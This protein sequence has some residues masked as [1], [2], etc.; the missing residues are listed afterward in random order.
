MAAAVISAPSAVAD[1][2]LDP[3]ARI[4]IAQSATSRRAAAG[5]EPGYVSMIIELTDGSD[6]DR[7]TAEG[8]V[9]WGQRENLVL[10]CVPADKVDEISR[11]NYVARMTLSRRLN[12]SLDLACAA[13]GVN[14]LHSGADGLAGLTGRGITVGFADSGFDPS[15]EVFDGRIVS[16]THFA[17]NEAKILRAETPAEIA[18]WSTD[19]ADMYHATHVGGILCGAGP[20][21]YQGVAAGASLVAATSQLY[22]AG[23]LACVE[24]VIARGRRAGQPVVVNMSLGSTIGPHDGT[25]PFC[26]YLDM[27]ADEAVIVLS[28][29]NDGNKEMSLSHTFTDNDPGLASLVTQR[30]YGDFYHLDSFYDCWSRDSRPVSIRIRAFDSTN[31]KYVWTSEWITAGDE[32]TTI[33]S[34]DRPD[35]ARYFKGTIMLAG[36][37]NPYNG[38][39]NA[40]IS[41]NTD[42]LQT[43]PNG[44]WAL[45]NLEIDFTGAP[46]VTADIY[47][48]TS[49][50][51]LGSYNL[52][53]QTKGNSDGSI[54]NLACGH[55][56]IS[57][58]SVNT[59]HEVKYPDGH[60]TVWSYIGDGPMSLTSSYGTLIDG[61]SLPHICA[62]GAV[63]ISAASRLYYDAHPDEASDIVYRTPGGDAYIPLSGTSMAA[64]HAA[65]IFALWLEAD[66]TLT[67]AEIRDI[68]VT[69]ASPIADGAVREG[70]GCI[71]ALAGLRYIIKHSGVTSP[72]LCPVV[73]RREGSRLVVESLD[74]SD[75]SAAVYDLT[76]RQIA[77]DALPASPVIVR[78][79]TASGVIVRK[80]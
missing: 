26:R 66:P 80:I 61:R 12:A 42:A 15:H 13:T 72:D 10:A 54:S 8:A 49:L 25:D 55:N 75:I 32:I 7:L 70:A 4:S 73:I 58:G 23:I 71:D 46:G 39:Y 17:D 43:S 57:V 59:R 78:V 45:H 69:T 48:E 2:V 40:Q 56:T 74:G 62:P 28:A 41:F 33:S 38:R 53:G 31:R 11:G 35:F 3:A 19:D 18:S 37:V 21:P 22:D 36:E 64:P 63:I 67:P 51:M 60:T 14:T 20:S 5:D 79:A 76:G 29:G 77:S 24:D 65:G 6:T 44:Q 9:I 47:A 52:P 16:V 27:C 30:Y 50:C 1:N 34:A 68:A